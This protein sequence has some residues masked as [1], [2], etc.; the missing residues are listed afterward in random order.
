LFFL[1]PPYAPSTRIASRIY[2]HELSEQDHKE[3]VARLLTLRGSAILSSYDHGM[4][5][6][7]LRAGWH[8]INFDVRSYAH[9]SSRTHRTE[10][11]W[12]SPEITG[13]MD[14]QS[15]T[16]I[17]KMRAGAH[18]THEIRVR[19]TTN[20]IIRA[21]DRLREAGKEPSIT[22]VASAVRLSREHLSRRYRHLFT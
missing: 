2:D 17:E 13:H 7:L 14:P 12:L 15:L 21:V 6:P 18:H 22:E 20:R 9:R 8:L 4:Y 3:M 16:A 11:L 5:K 10:C 19:E 1:D